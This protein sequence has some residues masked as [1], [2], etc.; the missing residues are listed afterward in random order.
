MI[1]K[2]ILP[3][4]TA[5]FF[6]MFGDSP[7]SI[8]IVKALIGFQI[9]DFLSALG[10]CALKDVKF[11]YRI[12]FKGILKKIVMLLAVSFGFYLDKTNV[13]NAG[14]VSFEISFAS[15]FITV[16]ILSILNNF[17][18]MGFNIPLVE[19]YIKLD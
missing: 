1:E 6:L 2:K 3:I 13:F 15:G 11:D 16:E 9:F 17:K 19:K 18:R 12:F 14:N 10:Y 5:L 7:A 4:L 8:K